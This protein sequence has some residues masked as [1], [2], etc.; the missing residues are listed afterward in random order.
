MSRSSSTTTIV[1]VLDSTSFGSARVALSAGAPS[2]DAS[3]AIASPSPTRRTGRSGGGH[4]TALRWRARV[5]QY[6][7]AAS[8][9]NKEGL[10]NLHRVNEQ[11]VPSE[12]LS[13]GLRYGPKD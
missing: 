2:P 4:E 10:P 8:W 6:R 1:A 12:R 11:H 13:G 3:A 9:C 5:V 7:R